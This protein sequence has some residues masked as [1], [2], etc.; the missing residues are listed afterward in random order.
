[1]KRVQ[2]TSSWDDYL[3]LQTEPIA[4]IRI[5]TKAPIFWLPPKRRRA[6][7]GGEPA[8]RSLE[9]LAVL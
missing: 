8:T 3:T 2:L 9:S 1:M 7:T 5:E 6:P 4:L